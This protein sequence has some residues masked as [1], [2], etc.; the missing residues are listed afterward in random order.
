M[1]TIVDGIE[2][3]QVGW[4]TININNYYYPKGTQFIGVAESLEIKSSNFTKGAC[5]ENYLA[6]T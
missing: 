1:S 2:I 3:P 6:E 4:Y 5:L